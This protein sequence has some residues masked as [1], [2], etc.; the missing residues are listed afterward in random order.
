MNLA[1]RTALAAGA[2]LLAANGGAWAADMLIEPD[3]Y[4]TS[5]PYAAERWREPPYEV[6]EERFRQRHVE[7]D[8]EDEIVPIPPRDVDG[9]WFEERRYGGFPRHAERRYAEGR[10]WHRRIVAPPRWR[11]GEDCRTLVR[12]EIKP[13][14]EVVERR[15]VVC[16]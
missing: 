5:R 10:H 1:W 11:D 12:R 7:R 14:G 15:K 3:R 16:D 8:E 4:E 9:P 2:A 13:W 6:R